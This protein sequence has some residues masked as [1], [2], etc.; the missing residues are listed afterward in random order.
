MIVIG[1]WNRLYHKNRNGTNN[2][3]TSTHLAIYY[4]PTSSSTDHRC[5]EMPNSLICAGEM[6]SLFKEFSNRA[7]LMHQSLSVLCFF[8]G[9]LLFNGKGED[10]TSRILLS[11]QSNDM[12]DCTTSAATS[13]RYTGRSFSYTSFSIG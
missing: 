3:K 4:L 11:F 7:E 2:N 6:V 12:S 8:V 10:A 5:V 13:S 1:Q 9:T